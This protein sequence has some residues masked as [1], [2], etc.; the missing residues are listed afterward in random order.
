MAIRNN[1]T[2]P[3][4]E[5]GKEEHSTVTKGLVHRYLGMEIDYRKQ[6]KVQI[7][8]LKYISELLHKAPKKLTITAVTPEAIHLLKVNEEKKK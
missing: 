7:S 2:K 4:K 1:I 5:F 3:K 8:M 6:G